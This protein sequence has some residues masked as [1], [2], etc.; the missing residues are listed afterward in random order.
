MLVLSYPADVRGMGKYVK[1]A[2]LHLLAASIAAAASV[3]SLALLYLIA[4]VFES[5]YTPPAC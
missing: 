3:G 4:V 2:L 5:A 1:L